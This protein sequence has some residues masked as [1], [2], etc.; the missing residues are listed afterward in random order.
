MSIRVNYEPAA[1]PGNPGGGAT[2]YWP[3]FQTRLGKNIRVYPGFGVKPRNVLGRNSVVQNTFDVLGNV[4][5][6]FL[7]LDPIKRAIG[8]GGWCTSATGT[9]LSFLITIAWEALYVDLSAS[10]YAAMDP[11]DPLDSNYYLRRLY[12][13]IL[14]RCADIFSAGH[15]VHLMIFD[16]SGFVPQ[17]AI[18]NGWTYTSFNHEFPDWNNSNMSDAMGYFIQAL[19]KVTGTTESTALRDNTNI[20]GISF[21]EYFGGSPGSTTQ[22]WADG[23]KNYMSIADVERNGMLLCIGSGGK[24]NSIGY[25]STPGVGTGVVEHAYALGWGLRISDCNLFGSSGNAVGSGAYPAGCKQSV[26]LSDNEFHL[27][28]KYCNYLPIMCE[29]QTNAYT[30]SLTTWPSNW[31]NNPFGYTGGENIGIPNGYEMYWQGTLNGPFPQTCFYPGMN[32]VASSYTTWPDD[33]ENALD[34]FSATGDESAPHF[35][36]DWVFE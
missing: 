20:A 5:S 31:D 8:S 28:Q 1:D 24:G 12:D 13:N 2:L 14:T 18:S 34:Q 30:S 21:T 11:Q 16:R 10:A 7:S 6:D 4:N 36:S 22:S 15:K 27:V 29:A 9:H 32:A 23:I 33:F 17:W 35:P 19:L 25:T 3:K 26:S